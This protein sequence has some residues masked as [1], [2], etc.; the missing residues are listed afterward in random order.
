[1]TNNTDKATVKIQTL[2][3][4]NEKFYIVRIGEKRFVRKS[5][6]AA[7]EIERLNSK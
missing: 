4:L 1:M 6:K 3:V 5:P 7:K 2:S